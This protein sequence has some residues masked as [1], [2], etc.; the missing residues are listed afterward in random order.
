MLIEQVGRE[1]AREIMSMVRENVLRMR[2]LA[3]HFDVPLEDGAAH[4]AETHADAREL[5]GWA[6]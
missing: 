5:E 4:L 3:N 1:A 2:S 6:A